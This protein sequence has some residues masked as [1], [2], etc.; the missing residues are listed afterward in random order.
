MDEQTQQQAR[1][2]DQVIGAHFGALYR[3]AMRLTRCR[4][5]AEDLVQDVILRAMPELQRLAT[6][7]APLAW[8][9]RV[10]YR[11][12]V[13]CVRHRKRSPI[14][15]IDGEAAVAGALSE[16]PGPEELTAQSQRHEQL[17][18]VWGELNRGQRALLA[19]HAAGHTLGELEAITGLSRNAI[20]VRL[21]RARG[22]LAELVGRATTKHLKEG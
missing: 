13:D 9:L 3:A 16:D 11:L 2:F 1:R 19:L 21:H 14:A 22:R 8:L 7:D 18:L 4:E 20:G 6:L 12:F 5:D 17:D 15:L 10:Q